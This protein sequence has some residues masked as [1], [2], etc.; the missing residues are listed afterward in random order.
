MNATIL[1]FLKKEL[2]QT[3]R[4]P[5]MRM[6]LFV[7]PVIQMTL[8]GFALSQEVRNVRLA[9]YAPASDAA[10]VRLAD[11]MMGGG[12]FVPAKNPPVDPYQAISAGVADAVLVAPPG[13]LQKALGRGGVPAQI[14][15]LVDATN[16]T[17]AR[18]VEN[19]ARAFL[20]TELASRT[21]R[22]ALRGG[23]QMD[24]RML[25]NPS[26]E[27]NFFMVPGIL[28]MLILLVTM[29]LTSSS[30]TREK[31]MG[32]FETLL[33]APV[34]RGEII[35]GKTLPYIL[36]GMADIPIVVAFATLVFGVPLRGAAWQM[37]LGGLVFVCS[38]V[39]LGTLISTIARNQQQAMMTS[40]FVTFPAQMLSGIIYPLD[41]M[42][43]VIRWVAYLNPMKYFATMVR[44][45]MLKGGDP[46][47]FWTNL[48]P[49]ALIAAA[50]IGI[51]LRRFRQTL[52]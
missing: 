36:L 46:V 51:S 14:Q 52:N 4:D 30:I 29:T 40:F 10:M 25:Y 21:P 49:M 24:V 5:R 22:G 12:L 34:T 6:M 23:L 2:R 45:I 19:Y 27:T 13:G 3:L 38:T 9:V 48:W 16:A 18:S 44:N 35:L 28:V 1:G 37:G 31:E 43:W 41:N 32:T 39:G 26:M 8:F 20:A 7:A 11:R 33:S 17:R 42:P 15:L 47:V 50:C